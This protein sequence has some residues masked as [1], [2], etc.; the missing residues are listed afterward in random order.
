MAYYEYKVKKNGVVTKGCKEGTLSD[1]R[2]GF[3]DDGYVILDLREVSEWEKKNSSRSFGAVSFLKDIFTFRRQVKSKKLAEFSSQFSVLLDAGMTIPECISL[4]VNNEKDTDFKAILQDMEKEINQGISL[5]ESIK[6]RG[7]LFPPIFVMLIRTGEYSGQ[8]A[9]IFKEL[10]DYFERIDDNKSRII[11]VCTY[12]AVLTVFL[13]I[14]L[15]V[16]SVKVVPVFREVF[17]DYQEELPLLTRMMFAAADFIKDGW[18]FL[19]IIAAALPTLVVLSLRNT[20]VKKILD[21]MVIVV[22]VIG[23]LVV[24]SS[25]NSFLKGL[26]LLLKNG[27]T[28]VQALEPSINIV[29]NHVIKKSLY[30]DTTAIM[31]GKPLYQLLQDNRYINDVTKTLVKTGESSAKF[32]ITLDKAIIYYNREINRKVD[33]INRLMEPALILV[34]GAIIGLVVISLA[35]PIFKISSGSLVG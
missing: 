12:P 6:N 19:V 35:I 32:D 7:S 4:M 14:N 2:K 28:I 13:L 23:K 20:A 30:R 18:L 3:I 10:A 11:G 24:D 26:A 17:S 29:G 33:R 1:L 15:I 22:P 5:S 34:F 21:R 9:A 16:M 27:M 8:V 25:I 31:E